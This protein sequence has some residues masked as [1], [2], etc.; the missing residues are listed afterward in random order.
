MKLVH[1]IGGINS[2]GCAEG[3]LHLKRQLQI[4]HIDHFIVVESELPAGYAHHDGVPFA[5]AAVTKDGSFEVFV[6]WIVGCGVIG[7]EA[8]GEEGLFGH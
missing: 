7:G 8:V 6:E 1:M 4:D 5:V 2:V 3:A